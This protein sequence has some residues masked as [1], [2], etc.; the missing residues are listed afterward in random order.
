MPVKLCY[1][2]SMY[3]E[4]MFYYIWNTIGVF[5]LLGIG[6]FIY[7]FLDHDASWDGIFLAII[8]HVYRAM[9]QY[10]FGI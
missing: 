3:K 4:D 1:N 10:Q 7:E 5:V 9:S 8:K 2:N 6:V